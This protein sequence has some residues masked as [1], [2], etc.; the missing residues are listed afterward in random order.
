M[1]K[2]QV[3]TDVLVIGAG[4]VGLFV[5][6]EAGLLG[7]RTHVI[8]NLN[9]IG[10]Q[11]IEIYPRKPIYDIPGLPE[12]M[13]GELI[14]RLMTQIKPF[15]PGFTLGERAEELKKT[16]EK[17]YQIITEQGTLHEAPVVVIAGGL[18]SFE[19]RKPPIPNIQHYEN[20]GVDYAIKDPEK[21]RKKQ[22][23]IAGGGDSAL[24]WTLELMNYTQHLSLIHRG[25]SFRAAPDSVQRLRT[26]VAEGRVKLYTHTEATDIAGT[27]HVERIQ[28]KTQGK[29][30]LWKETDYYIPL[31]GLKPK[32]GPLANWG[33]EI[34][35]N[36]LRVNNAKDYQTNLPGVYAVGDISTYPGK[37]KLILCG[38]HEAAVAMQYAYQ[39]IHPDKKF[40]MKYTTV[41]GIQGFESPQP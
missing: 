40:V 4:P 26:C 16:E 34:E 29:D 23:I 6:F 9:R 5:V 37:L 21:Y 30:I 38:F 28:L 3:R 8:D 15:Q 12:V 22:V 13:A 35:K 19:P 32:L 27:E 33:I 14:Q 39:H 41:N 17:T 10:G 1:D 2:T 20:K 36:A 24:D 7:L 18:G 25:E 11:C 31:F